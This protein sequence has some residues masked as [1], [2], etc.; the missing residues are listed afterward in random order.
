MALQKEPG[1][2]IDL[3]GLGDEGL[4]A[5]FTP[6]TSEKSMSGE[7]LFETSNTFISKS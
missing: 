5:V 1:R 6:I 4:K 3:G 2:P 7:A